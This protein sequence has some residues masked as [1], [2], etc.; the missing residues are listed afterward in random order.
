MK[1]DAFVIQAVLVIL[2]PSS[3]AHPGSKWEQKLKEIRAA[4]P[5]DSPEDST[6]LIGDLVNGG[7]KT[8]VGKVSFLRLI[9]LHK[10]NSHRP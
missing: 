4:A 7:A 6:E 5:I 1:V 10:S 9:L 3:N 8:A 2:L